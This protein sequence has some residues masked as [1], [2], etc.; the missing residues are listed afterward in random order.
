MIEEEILSCEI[1][2]CLVNCAPDSCEVALLDS[3]VYSFESGRKVIARCLSKQHQF[4]G[5]VI[6]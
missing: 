5:F 1:V 2:K 4:F 6:V 3:N